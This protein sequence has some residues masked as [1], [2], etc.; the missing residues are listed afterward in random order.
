MI[1]YLVVGLFII[2]GLAGGP[3]QRSPAPALRTATVQ[4]ETSGDGV[5]TTVEVE[6]QRWI[7]A[8]RIGLTISQTSRSCAGT[9]CQDIPAIS[10][11]TWQTL[12][13][14]DG[15]IDPILA[16]AAVH[17]T[18]P[19]HDNVTNADVI[20]RID[21]EWSGTGA[22]FCGV[23]RDAVG[24]L[25]SAAVTGEVAI[26]SRRMIPGLTAPDGWIKQRWWNLPPT[27]FVP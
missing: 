19:V 12:H 10:V 27:S 11:T 26:G 6:I 7:D 16:Y 14:G 21:V 22:T 15:M 23:L 25:R 20:V 4:F 9:L 24:C 8:P 3:L 2:A 13:S 1:K 5:E 18:L 17:A